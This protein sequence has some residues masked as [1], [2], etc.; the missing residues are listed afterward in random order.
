MATL[1]IPFPDKFR[2][3][4]RIGTA[5]IRSTE[6]SLVQLQQSIASQTS[7]TYDSVLMALRH[8]QNLE[9]GKRLADDFLKKTEARFQAGTT[10]RLDV[11]KAR[12]DVAQAENDLIASER[13][14]A[15][16]RASLNRLLARPLG[17]P[18]AVADSLAVPED[19]PPLD[20][21][22]AAAIAT[23]PELVGLQRQQEGAKAGTALVRQYWLP[24]FTVGLSK[25]YSGPGPGVLF[26][27]I[28]MPL[29]VFFWQHSKGEIAEAKHRELELAAGYQDFRAQVALEVRG[30]H[31]AAATSLRQAT[32][33]RDQLVPAAREAFR[34]ASVSYG[35]GGSSALE[36]L[37]ARR[38]LRD[39]E[40]QF[41][42]A[43]AAANMTRADLERAVARPLQSF[44]TGASRD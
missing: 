38:T 36:V 27:G 21:L 33:L 5:D 13:E 34:I 26:S 17:A 42:D 44:A 23:R 24:D 30:A 19:L 6:A 12:V 15:N 25:N 31:A 4:G 35:L 10:A 39:A 2:L 8:R 32:F 18:L 43:L 37:D 7:Q 3:R 16:A 9:E 40:N 20:Q 14:V 22:E 28:S 1:T 11:I 41:T 29:P